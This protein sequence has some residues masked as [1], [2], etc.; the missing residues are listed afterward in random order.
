MNGFTRTFRPMR[1]E[2]AQPPF[3][4]R[5]FPDWQA[6][7]T[8]TTGRISFDETRI[9]RQRGTHGRVP[10]PWTAHERLLHQYR[11]TRRGDRLRRGWEALLLRDF[12]GSQAAQVVR[13][14]LLDRFTPSR[15]SRADRGGEAAHSPKACE[16]FRFT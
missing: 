6:S 11:R 15:V 14:S 3:T 1:R 12:L 16:V 10:T 4:E 8:N 13:R 2:A 7:N 9:S 5:I